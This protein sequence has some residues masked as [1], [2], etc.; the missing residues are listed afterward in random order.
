VTLRFM[1]GFLGSVER[2]L[3]RGERRWKKKKTWR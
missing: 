1:G 3:P 2:Q